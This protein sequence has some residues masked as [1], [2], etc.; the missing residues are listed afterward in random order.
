[1]TDL[2]PESH[3]IVCDLGFGDAG[4]G[5]VVDYL[6]RRPPGPDGRRPVR[7]VVRYNGGAQAAHNVVTDDGRHHTFAQFGSGTF[8][9]VPTHLSRFMLV[10]PL[11]LAAEAHHLTTLGVPDPF[12]LLTVDRRAL[13]T[14][15]YHAAANRLGERRRGA[16][17]HGSCGLGIG[18]TARYALDHPDDAPT[19]GDC[20]SRGR[21]LARLTLL[22]DRLAHRLGLAPDRLPAPPPADCVGA[23]AA[24]AG[25]VRL[26]DETALPQL[27][28]QG[29]VVFEGAQGV[30][31]DEHHGFHPYTT[32]STTT[33]A[34]A[35]TLLAEAGLPS[36]ALR[37]G[38]L[39]S[40][41]TRHGPGPL[42][43][44]DKHLAVPEPHNSTG[45]WQGPF[46]IGHFD[47][48]AHRY[49][50]A[51]AG[52][53]DAL[54]LTHLDAPAR[55]PAL[56][57]CDTYD[58]DDA[59]LHTLTPGRPGDLT[60]Q[61]QLTEALTRARPGR[62]T[63]PGPDPQTWSA[64][65]AHRLGTPV[66]LESHGPTARQ[67]HLRRAPVDS[68]TIH[69]MTT[70]DADRTS[71]GPGSHCHWCGAA[72]A[73]GTTGWPRACPGCAEITYRNP[74]PVVV[75][76][77]PV[78]A[79]EAN[80]LVVIRRTIEPGYGE[81]ALPGGYIDYGESWQQACVRELR[82][83]TGIEAD[84]GRVALVATDSD[85]S[86]GFLCLFGMLPPRR[87]DE[88]PPSVPTDETEGWQFLPNPSQLAFPFHTRV[89]HAWFNGEYA[90]LA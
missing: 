31:L 78:I 71:Y 46:R 8:S 54:A 10:D 2:L 63:D 18:E 48:V 24:F 57:L 40:Y 87:I 22:R 20:T 86:G 13:L 53:A 32:W 5:T 84:A 42:P 81:L 60:A 39:R 89:S 79:P 15:P 49:A 38:V 74:L 28:R 11:A 29:P 77:L 37:L 33:F 44:E 30:L 72:Y 9:G 45:P 70:H 83:E 66:L 73:P 62:L 85:T 61:A 82:E 69:P 25:R 27:L 47:T 3:V 76:L 68:V 16:A 17:R 50:L 51:V 64:A 75:T 43:T 52:G 21:L 26:T 7:A 6:C 14:T 80:G 59:P 55:H 67:K 41:T 35:E 58:L 12:A 23:F 56:R 4:K 19:A 1:M 34:N 65:I 90:H 36:A 88:L